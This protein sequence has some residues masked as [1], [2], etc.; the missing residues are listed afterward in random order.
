MKVSGGEAA[1]PVLPVWQT[2][3]GLSSRDVQC[4]SPTSPGY[5]QQQQQQQ[6]QSVHG[7]NMAAERLARRDS[8]PLDAPS[9]SSFPYP[10]RNPPLPQLLIPEGDRSPGLL[11][12]SVAPPLSAPP[13]VS[14]GEGPA[15]PLWGPP[16]SS[17]TST[18]LSN[19]NLALH[20]NNNNNNHVVSNNNVSYATSPKEEEED[21]ETPS[22]FSF[23]TGLPYQFM[24]DLYRHTRISSKKMRKRV[25]QKN[26]ECNVSPSNVAKRRRRYLQDIFT[27]LVDIQWRWTL[28]VF[29]MSFISSWMLFAVVWWLIAYTHGDLEEQHLPHKQEESRWTPC[30]VNVFSFTSCFLFSVE[31]QHTIG[32]GSRHTTEQCPEAIF[33]MCLQSITGV[34]IQ[35]FMVGIVFAKLSR[36]KKRTQTLLFSRNACLC[37]RDGEMCLLFRVGDMRKS[38]I[39]EA[40]VRAQLIRKRV[41]REGEILPFFQYEL[42]VGY[43]IGEDRIFFIWP[44]TMVHKIN[45]NSPL[46]DLSAHDLL[47]EKFEIVVILEGVIESTGMTTQARS[48]YLPNEI[49]WG[50]RFEPLVTFNKELG[51]YAVDYSLFNNTYQVNTPLYSARELDRLNSQASTPV[52]PL[53]PVTPMSPLTPMTP[54]SATGVGGG[55]CALDLHACPHSSCDA[56]Q[57]APASRPLLH[58][59]DDV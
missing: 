37:L 45:E 5:Q 31:T 23:L 15:R 47:R 57:D 14:T 39:I 13:I 50:Y 8:C 48:S 34:M 46:Y 27:T 20:N 38:H 3:K 25:V 32:Y 40:H 30:V 43:D 16:S 24:I 41:T 17:T 10:G 11:N 4:S 29:A 21:V 52:T 2:L 33:V 1:G 19:T 44:M 54:T 56:S 55:S 58:E 18:S 12:G 6:Q 28:L 49:L 35:A 36:P 51:E 9:S 59:H 42:D 53:T 22:V 7:S 26:G